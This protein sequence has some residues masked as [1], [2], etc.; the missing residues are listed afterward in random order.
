MGLILCLVAQRSRHQRCD[1]QLHSAIDS[2]LVS[3]HPS[4]SFRL[5]A[6][7]LWTGAPAL[8]MSARL[9]KHNQWAISRGENACH[10]L[11]F[12][13][14]WVREIENICSGK[15]SW[16]HADMKHH[17]LSEWNQMPQMEV[18]ASSVPTSLQRAYLQLSE[19][20]TPFISDLN[21][22]LFNMDEFFCM[23]RSDT[24]HQNT[25]FPLIR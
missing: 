17:W 2:S 15:A 22:Y 16:Y 12:H 19:K 1:T 6:K 10:Y 5:P 20:T 3:R 21:N 23:L 4:L 24:N 25:S 9:L 11:Y 18:P 7:C 14:V 13:R 8:P